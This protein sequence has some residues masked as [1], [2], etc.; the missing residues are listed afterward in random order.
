MGQGYQRSTG[1]RPGSTSAVDGADVVKVLAVLT[2]IGLVI[3]LVIAL[4]LLVLTVAA[5]GLVAW[6]AVVLVQRLRAH[7]RAVQERRDLEAAAVARA[8]DDAPV[9]T[10]A[11]VLDTLP[12]HLRGGFT[13]PAGVGTP[14]QGWSPP[15]AL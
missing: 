14:E 13:T 1:R 11:E 5:L 8:D 10:F 2:A 15:R 4:V 7:R 6:G 9:H 3:G 12:P